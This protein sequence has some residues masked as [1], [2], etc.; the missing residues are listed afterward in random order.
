MQGYVLVWYET[1]HGPVVVLATKNIAGYRNKTDP[2]RIVVWHNAGQL[3]IPGGGPKG[4][5]QPEKTALR[6][7]CEETG[8]DLEDAT[9]RRSME[10]VGPPE[11][12]IL[13]DGKDSFCVVYQRVAVAS[14]VV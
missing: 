9:V 2:E 8:V 14:K 7:F 10:C 3:A 6:E 5:E 13:S 1:D 12:K 4:N 11:K